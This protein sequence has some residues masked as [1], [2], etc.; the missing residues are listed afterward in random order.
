[1]GLAYGTS[2]RGACHLRAT[3]YKPELAKMIDPDQI[4]GKAEMFVEWEDR[5][6]IFDALVL[7]RFYRD[8]YQWENLGEM[9]RLL[10]GMELGT[11]DMRTIAGRISNDTRRFNVREGLV[12]DDD[13]LPKRFTTE[14]LPETQ[15][16]ITRDQMDRLLR[17]YY[18]ARGWNR[19]GHPPQNKG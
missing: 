16:I 9:I 15:K 8:L 13:R 1:M 6:I 14:T 18:T 3:F 17:D 10:T 12:P 2:P 11:E 7:C 5:L 4:E 19:E